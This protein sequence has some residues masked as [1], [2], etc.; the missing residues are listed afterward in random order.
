MTDNLIE[1]DNR[2]CIA[3]GCI[4]GITENVDLWLAWYP[5][6]HGNKSH[7]NIKYIASGTSAGVKDVTDFLKETDKKKGANLH[8]LDWD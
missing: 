3:S 2:V 8:Y 4:L 1:K 5:D 7:I 6:Y